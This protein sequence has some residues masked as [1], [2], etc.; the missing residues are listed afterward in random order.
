MRRSRSISRNH[1]RTSI[2]Q[3][4]FSDSF[5][6]DAQEC[7]RKEKTKK[8]SSTIVNKLTNNK[9]WWCSRTITLYRDSRINWTELESL[10]PT[11]FEAGWPRCWWRRRRLT[12]CTFIIICRFVSRDEQRAF[13]AGHR[14][15]INRPV[16]YF[17]G[18]T[19]RQFWVN[20]MLELT[21]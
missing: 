10:W 17:F 11:S 18:S 8:I 2:Q 1:R 20:R 13:C 4:S 9:H 6:D 19:L 7:L 16:P 21:N 3:L 14:W 12:F 15:P 5:A